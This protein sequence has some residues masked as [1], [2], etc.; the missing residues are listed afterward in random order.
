[1]RSPLKRLKRILF[2]QVFTY[3]TVSAGLHHPV[4]Q[5]PSPRPTLC[6]LPPGHREGQLGTPMDD[7]AEAFGPSSRR[8]F[9]LPK[10]A[11][12]DPRVWKKQKI[13][14]DRQLLLFFSMHFTPETS[15]SV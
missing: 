15:N 14:P 6:L 10:Y 11:V 2:Q 13:N 4:E 8:F 9:V 3:I 1:M 12:C 7:L 5:F